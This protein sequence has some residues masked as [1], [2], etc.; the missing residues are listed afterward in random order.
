MSSHAI[1]CWNYH[2]EVYCDKLNI[3]IVTRATTKKVTQK[4]S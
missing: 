4:I 1:F 3:H 2:T